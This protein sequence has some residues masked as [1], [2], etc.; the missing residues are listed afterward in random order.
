MGIEGGYFNMSL[1]L[2][3]SRDGQEEDMISE[4]VLH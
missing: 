1:G 2:D 4:E 3:L